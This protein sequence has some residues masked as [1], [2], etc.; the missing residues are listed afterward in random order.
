LKGNKSSEKTAGWGYRYNPVVQL[1]GG[2]AV[3]AHCASAHSI[4]FP[5]TVPNAY[6]NSISFTITNPNVHT[7]ANT[8]TGTR[9]LKNGSHKRNQLLRR[10]TPPHPVKPTVRPNDA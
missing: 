3:S 5:L 2:G 8:N 6:T 7:F 9:R 10:I 4:A 1:V